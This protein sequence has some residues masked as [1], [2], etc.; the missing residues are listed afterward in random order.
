MTL[1]VYKELEQGSPEWL[2]ARRGIVTASTV[3]RLVTPTLKVARNDTARGYLLN[4][5]AER[6]TGHIEPVFVNADM[7]RGTDEEPIARDAYADHRGVTVQEVG[8]MTTTIDGATVG[9]SPDGLVGEDGLIEIKSRR[10]KK[11]VSTILANQVP[12]E[13]MAQI[14]TGLL[15]SG[16][17]WCDFISYSNGMHLYI[18][19]VWPDTTWQQAIKEAVHEAETTIRTYTDTYTDRVKDMPLMERYLD[20]DDITF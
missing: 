20:A 18:T 10:Q 6:I 11:Q 8:F 12:A 3:G 7:Q 5:A 13:N 17:Q 15:V 2:E 16:R 19:R 9:F 14:Q 4:L 1:T